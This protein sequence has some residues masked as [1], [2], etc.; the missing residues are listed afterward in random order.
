MKLRPEEKQKIELL[1]KKKGVL[2]KRA[3]MDAV[4]ELILISN[5][6]Q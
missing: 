5:Y 1:A 2:K 6:V 4:N 3:V